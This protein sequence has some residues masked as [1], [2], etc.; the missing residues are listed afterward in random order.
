MKYH[1][2]FQYLLIR[3]D[4]SRKV[5]FRNLLCEGLVQLEALDGQKPAILDVKV[6][7][8]PWARFAHYLAQCWQN[9]STVHPLFRLQGRLPDS[10]QTSLL[11]ASL[12]DEDAL[13]ILRA[14]RKS[15]ILPPVRM[16]VN[17]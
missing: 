15:G 10:I 3:G 13:Q 4:S 16:S 14:L 6:Q 9:S 17:C 5:R 2:S 11:A 8:F 12:P 7:E 1:S